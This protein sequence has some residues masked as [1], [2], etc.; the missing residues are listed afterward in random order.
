MDGREEE[1]DKKRKL[2]LE[3]QAARK[4]EE[5]IRSSNG[6]SR[7]RAW[8]KYCNAA[9][10]TAAA[11]AAA[12]RPRHD[13]PKNKNRRADSPKTK[14]SE[15]CVFPSLS[16]V[17]EEPRKNGYQ[18]RILPEKL[19]VWTYFQPCTT[20]FHQKYVRCRPKFDLDSRGT[21]LW[22]LGVRVYGA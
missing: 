20:K 21:G 4:R 22:C 11:A 15:H 8:K 18:I 17:F 6:N 16:Q 7:Y 19:S 9:A 14:S 1:E 13:R 12:A 2:E 3:A 10:A 5:D